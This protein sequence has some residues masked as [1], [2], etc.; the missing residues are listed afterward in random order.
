MTE[1]FSSWSIT[2]VSSLIS[3]VTL[4]STTML[5]HDK[6]EQLTINTNTFTV[7]AIVNLQT[8]DDMV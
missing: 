6:C 4:A 2:I 8:Y 7:A 1:R 3:P 5:N